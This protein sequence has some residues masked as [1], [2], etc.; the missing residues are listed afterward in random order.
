MNVYRFNVIVLGL[1]DMQKNLILNKKLNFLKIFHILFLI[2]T[3]G[4]RKFGIK[5]IKTVTDLYKRF[6]CF[7]I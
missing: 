6:P 3:K 7:V 5:T 2:Y 1:F 4:K